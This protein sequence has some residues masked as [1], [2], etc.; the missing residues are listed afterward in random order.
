M[1]DIFKHKADLSAT[2]KKHHIVYEED[3]IPN[4]EYPSYKTPRLDF[5]PLQEID[6]DVEEFIKTISSKSLPPI[7]VDK[8]PSLTST[9]EFEESCETIKK[10]IRICNAPIE[11]KSIEE[12]KIIS[13][14]IEKITNEL[15]SITNT[16]KPE[17]TIFEIKESK[18]INNLQ[19][20]FNYLIFN[21]NILLHEIFN[22]VLA[23]ILYEQ[24]Y[25]VNVYIKKQETGEFLIYFTF[26]FYLSININTEGKIFITRKDI[27]QQLENHD[28]IDKIKYHL[29]NISFYTL[30]LITTSKFINL[31]IYNNYFKSGYD[32]LSKL[33]HTLEQ[34][35]LNSATLEF[36]K[37]KI[38]FDKFVMLYKKITKN[39]E[40]I[41][42]H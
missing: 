16:I 22:P 13:K 34:Y 37:I 6:F 39:I 19:L 4:N 36:N 28:E 30:D 15:Q 20:L 14:E 35:K 42:I 21:N 38:N 32:L 23:T 11:K 26:P 7:V 5:E 41:P 25:K 9:F 12:D 18:F 27:Y 40:L 29:K 10:L 33:I 2:T 3:N 17:K 1:S 31:I 24:M 8:K